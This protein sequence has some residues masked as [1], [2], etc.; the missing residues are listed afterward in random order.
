MKK[1]TLLVAFFCFAIGFSQTF[2][3][4]TGPHDMQNGNGNT[5]ATC[6]TA[7]ELSLPLTV[8]GVGTLGGT[9]SI[10]S[11][12]LNITHTWDGDV[13]V[14]LIDPTGTVTVDLLT[15]VGGSGDNFTATVFSDSGSDI[16]GGAAP[17]TGTFTPMNGT[18]ADF[19]VAAIDADGDWT[20][21]VCDSANGDVGTVDDWSITFIPTPSCASPT[22]A[23]VSGVT[24]DAADFT[25]TSAESSFDIELVDITGGGSATGT[26]TVTGHPASPYNFTGLTDSNDYEVYVRADCGGSTSSWVGP[27][28]FTTLALPPSNDDC[29]NA[30]SLT[31]DAGF[32]DGVANNGDNSG[33]TDSAENDAS[34]FNNGADNDVWFSFTVPAGVATVDVSTDFTGGTLVDTEI[35]LYSGA[36]GSLVELAC[37]QDEGVTVLSNGFSWNSLITDAAVNEG[38]TYYVQVAGYGTGDQGTFCLDISTNQTL[39]INNIEDNNAFEYYPNPVNNKLNLRAQNNIQNVS[40]Y[41]MLGQE[42]I[43]T[44]PNLASSDVDM[45]A[46]QAGAYFVQVTIENKTETIRIIK[47]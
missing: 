42:V 37:S 8:T 28:A 34:C 1:I 15:G 17:F 24:T 22:A 41:N 4:N 26:P 29:A 35:A 14:S 13:N 16:T 27:I 2:T 20:L 10:E 46:L 18:M 21:S 3:D 32:C 43:R 9:N 36:C 44:S 30:I 39:S 12:T 7:D 33:A 38:E 25:W 45:S 19:N 5:D 23:A 6:G 47:K 31:V 11:V 40:V